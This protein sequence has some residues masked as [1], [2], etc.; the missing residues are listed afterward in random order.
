M[1]SRTP[2]AVPRPRRSLRRTLAAAVLGFE[3]LTVFFAALV[4]MTQSS[5]G[6]TTALGSGGALAV[7]CLVAAGLLRSPVGTAFGWVLQV[8]IVVIGV[9]VPMMFFLGAVFAALWLTALRVGGR[10]DR[11]KAAYAE[12]A[13]RQA[14]SSAA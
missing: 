14:S 10:I 12:A 7:A 3:G 11:E 9:W 8:L 5:L 1:S 13:G 6:R 4:A 2:G